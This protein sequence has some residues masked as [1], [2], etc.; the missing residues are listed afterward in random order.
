MC[1]FL[2]Y[3]MVFVLVFLWIIIYVKDFEDEYEIIDGIR[4]KKELIVM[5]KE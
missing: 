5:I 3:C 4:I 2:R 1:L